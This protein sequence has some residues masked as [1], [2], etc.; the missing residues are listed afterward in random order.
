MKSSMELILNRSVDYQLKNS[1]RKK[2]LCSNAKRLALSAS[3]PIFDSHLEISSFYS[4]VLTAIKKGLFII[5]CI[6]QKLNSEEIELEPSEISDLKDQKSSELASIKDCLSVCGRMISLHQSIS[7]DFVED[8]Y[9]NLFQKAISDPQLTV[10]RVNKAIEEFNNFNFCLVFKLLQGIG[11]PFLEKM[12]LES[13]FQ[14]CD[15]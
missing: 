14:L 3:A 4:L 10:L 1:N 15:R 5:N 2:C 13:L 9:Y 12:N 6:E 7:L 8:L 11:R